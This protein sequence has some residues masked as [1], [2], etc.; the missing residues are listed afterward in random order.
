MTLIALALL[1]LTAAPTTWKDAPIIDV[2]CATDAAA[3]PD[4][5]T[6][7]CALDCADGGFVIVVNGDV[8]K[9]DAKG[10][11]LALAALKATKKTEKLRVTVVGERTGDT[12]KVQSLTLQ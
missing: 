12:I 10:N 7:D 6:R 9:L 5:H 8:L 2:S 11:E 1:L 4:G 3:K